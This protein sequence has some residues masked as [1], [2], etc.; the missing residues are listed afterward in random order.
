MA[1]WFGIPTAG[2]V[3]TEGC[4]C[5]TP[6]DPKNQRPYRDKPAVGPQLANMIR[7]NTVTLDCIR[8]V[9]LIEIETR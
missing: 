3:P 5:T 4:F 8:I 2:I 7:G 1:T 6:R 9:D